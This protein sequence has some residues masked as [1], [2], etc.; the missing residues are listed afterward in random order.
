MGLGWECKSWILIKFSGE[1][2]GGLESHFGRCLLKQ[3]S[4]NLT[5]WVWRWIRSPTLMCPH[6]TL[7]C[8]SPSTSLGFLFSEWRSF[9]SLFSLLELFSFPCLPMVF[10]LLFFYCWEKSLSCFIITHFVKWDR[11]IQMN[12][13]SLREASAYVSLYISGTAFYVSVT[14]TVFMIC[15]RKVLNFHVS[16]IWNGSDFFKSISWQIQDL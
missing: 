2:T 14:Q 6:E 5:L 7:L 3:F 15:T 16:R 4:W 9:M 10:P 13:L 8:S 12:E 1:A 11:V